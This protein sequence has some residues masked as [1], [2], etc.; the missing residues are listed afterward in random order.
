[1]STSAKMIWVICGFPLV[2]YIS[3]VVITL[4]TKN[5]LQGFCIYT[6]SVQTRQCLTLPKEFKQEV[7]EIILERVFLN[8]WYLNVFLLFCLSYLG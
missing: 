4:T 6:L 5:I 1:M 2:L 8:C 7:V 3:I